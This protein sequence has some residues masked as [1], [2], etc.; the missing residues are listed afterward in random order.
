MIELIKKIFIAL[1]NAN[2]IRD[3]K[4]ILVYLSLLKI[5]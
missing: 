3:L 2:N 4:K 1:N 5:H